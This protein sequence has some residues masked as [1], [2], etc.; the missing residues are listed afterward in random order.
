MIRNDLIYKLLLAAILVPAIVFLQSCGD[1]SDPRP[2]PEDILKIARQ[3]PEPS[4][5]VNNEVKIYVD[6]S[7]SM[8]GFISQNDKQTPSIYSKVLQQLS[9]FNF[10]A[11]KISFHTFDGPVSQS[12]IFAMAN[13]RRLFNNRNTLL[14][15][16]F[17][18]ILQESSTPACAY[19]ILTD[20]IQDN[21]GINNFPAYVNPVISWIQKKNHTL[22]IYGFRSEFNGYVT[23]VTKNVAPV[24]LQS[25]PGDSNS[26]RPFYL[27]CFTTDHKIQRCLKSEIKNLNIAN[28]SINYSEELFQVNNKG[29]IEWKINKENKI[30][31]FKVCDPI[32]S[33]CKTIIYLMLKPE[34]QGQHHGLID[35]EM[36][37]TAT[38]FCKQILYESVSLVPHV[39]VYQWKVKDKKSNI[40]EKEVSGREFEFVK[41]P[42][43]NAKKNV[44]ENQPS[45]FVKDGTYKLSLQLKCMPAGWY[46]YH[47]KM[48]L[49]ESAFRVPAWIE[50]WSTIDDSISDNAT[51]TLHFRNAMVSILNN[52]NANKSPVLDFFL[53]IQY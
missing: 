14:D 11:Y 25:N 24:A 9:A 8:K 48:S 12:D 45:Q 23:P 29:K 53:A 49:A 40:K 16:V 36:P 18:E 34:K 13:N 7:G 41:L 47:I 6:N 2:E 5:P 31:I 38:A 30:K 3:A 10:A 35:V 4:M 42:E 51:K 21:Q 22:I 33:E 26:F 19:F 20:A 43:E 28:E 15:Q 32:V 39:D 50:N 17:T 27:F 44:S 1:F 37:I 52:I 46:V